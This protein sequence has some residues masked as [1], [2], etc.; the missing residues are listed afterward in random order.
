MPLE[1]RRNTDKS[2]KSRWWYGSYMVNGKR[3]V[4]SLGVKIAGTVPDSLKEKSDTDF[5]VSR[6]RA[7]AAL[8]VLIAKAMSRKSA[9]AQLE[10]IY[11]IRTGQKVGSIALVDMGAKWLKAPHARER[12]ARYVEQSLATIKAFVEF[13]QEQMPEAKTLDRVTRRVAEA[14]LS[15]LQSENLCPS[16]YNDKLVLLRSVFKV[17][18]HDAGMAWNP[19]DAIPTRKRTS[20]HRKPFTVAE[21]KKMLEKATPILRPV[22]VTGICTAMRRGDCCLLKWADVDLDQGYITVKTSKTG[23]TAEIPIFPMLR[24]E[25]EKARQD[26][27]DSVAD[28][29]GDGYVWPEAAQMFLKNRYGITWRTQK[30]IGDAGIK[31]TVQ[32]TLGKRNASVK[33]FHSLRTTWITIALSAGVPM[34]L[35]RRVTGHATTDVVL[36]HYF[37]PGRKDFKK[38]LN[39]A[40]PKLLMKSGKAVENLKYEA[41]VTPAARILAAIESL[42]QMTGRNWKAKRE[43]AL[44]AAR[45]AAEWLDGHIVHEKPAV[46]T[47]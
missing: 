2:L 37:R 43:E 5:E 45:S 47:V 22:L 32:A 12:S 24:E 16:T 23:E 7:E 28:G 34:E 44:E 41:D 29:K 4:S 40:M 35:V 14:W 31:D 17:L 18:K 11:E 19:F 26:Q 21:I 13:V 46:V 36:K 30:A 33:D 8:E 20:V 1:I 39:S 38:A 9:E 10:Q 27:R 25:L 15:D 6:A 3:H 42:E